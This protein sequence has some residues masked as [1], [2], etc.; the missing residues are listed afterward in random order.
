MENGELYDFLDG[1]AAACVAELE[2]RHKDVFW[3]DEM[4]ELAQC[5]FRI[6]LAQAGIE[7]LGA[8]SEGMRQ[9]ER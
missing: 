1:T 3:S 9:S 5:M 7:V 8:I 2:D 4:R 6:K